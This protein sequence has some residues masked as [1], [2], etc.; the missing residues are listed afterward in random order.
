MQVEDELL[1]QL[2]K[3]GLEERLLSKLR[4]YHH[5]I[6]RESALMLLGLEA[7]SSSPPRPETLHQATRASRPAL[8]RVR[9]ER[10][11]P[12][13]VFDKNG[14]SSR[15]QR[16]SVSDHSGAGTLVLYDSACSACEQE[17]LSGDLVEAG[18]VRFRGGELHLLPGAAM[19][20][21]QK[22]HRLKIGDS[23]PSSIG[24]FE[25][26]VS[27]FFGDFP[28][29]KGQSKLNGESSSAL[30]SAFELTDSSGK[31]RVVLWDSPGLA[32]RLKTGTPIE[33]ENGQ[34]RGGEI[35]VNS[36]GRLLMGEEAQAPRPKIEKMQIEEK[37]GVL[38]FSIL[39]S[40]SRS[41]VFP[42]LEEAA[43]R[44]GAGP[45]PEG[46]EARTVVE[47]KMKEWTGKALPVEWEKYAANP[48]A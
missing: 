36:S 44:L 32:G 17:A 38:S 45:V 11:F 21:M 14:S 19:K 48:K 46:I 24:H 4:E 20:R 41:F 18:P 26:S 2:G 31:A 15:S 7:S 13:R 29:K 12:A 10:V 23:S 28:Y 9:V 27:A 43:L 8:V 34:R 22:G 25:G 3:D 33:I 39:S 42:S 47:L 1:A 35:H 6:P 40:D 16:V 5:L 37:E 30:M